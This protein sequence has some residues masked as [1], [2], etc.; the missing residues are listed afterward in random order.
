MIRVWLA[1]AIAALWLAIGGLIA[2]MAHRAVLEIV[3]VEAAS[4]TLAL[5]GIG[6][7]LADLA[8]R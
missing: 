3:C 8:R 6:A 7:L 1:A 5:V 2:L 4:V